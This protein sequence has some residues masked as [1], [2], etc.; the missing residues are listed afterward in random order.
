[1]KKL[2]LLFGIMFISFGAFATNGNHSTTSLIKTQ[3]SIDKRGN[4]EIG[5]TIL[6]EEQGT[7]KVAVHNEFTIKLQIPGYAA[8]DVKIK[9]D[10]IFE[11]ANCK[12]AAKAAAVFVAT[13][14]KEL[15]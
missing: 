10:L 4:L 6:Q 11:A 3:K 1:M 7:C 5:V 9:N 15:A 8:F 12:E 14:V 13:I 2:I